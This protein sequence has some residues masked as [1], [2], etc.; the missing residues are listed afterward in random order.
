MRK[1]FLLLAALLLLPACR[2]LPPGDA[3]LRENMRNP[4]FAQNYYS[5]LV[6]HLVN[7]QI[8]NDPVIASGA[9]KRIA[10][11]AREEALALAQEASKKVD[12]GILGIFGAARE[13]AK[14]TA[15]IV[16]DQLYFG[17][18]FFVVPGVDLRVYVTNLVDPRETPFPDESASNLGPLKSP[19]G[20]QTYAVT[21]DKQKATNVTVVLYDLMLKR[22]HGFAQLRP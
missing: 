21:K 3:A 20:I 8:H 4:L 11:S 17:T 12:E 2:T 10:D 6:D 9:T 22:M 13:E 14:G 1:I 7:L 5:E 18:D 15:L 19:F 16:D